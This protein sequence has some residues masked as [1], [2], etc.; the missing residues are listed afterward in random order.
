LRLHPLGQQVVTAQAFHPIEH[1]RDG[2]HFYREFTASAGDDVSAYAFVL[3]VP[4][5]APFPAEQH[6]KPAL[7]LVACHCGDVADG[8]SSLESMASFGEPF[9]AAVQTVPY[10]AAQQAFD[11]GLPKGLRWYSRAH[12]LD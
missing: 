4:P 3:R 9:L 11:A 5:V 6:G 2:L 8:T 7:A 1:L 12:F 10:T